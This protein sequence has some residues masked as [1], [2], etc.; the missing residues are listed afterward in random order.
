MNPISDMISP[1]AHRTAHVKVGDQSKRQRGPKKTTSWVL[2]M[3]ILEQATRQGCSAMITGYVGSLNP[4]N[5]PPPAAGISK[6]HNLQ[7]SGT[8]V[9]ADPDIA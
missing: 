4:G 2:S 9:L 5:Q 3:S 6:P 1:K 8:L 7:T